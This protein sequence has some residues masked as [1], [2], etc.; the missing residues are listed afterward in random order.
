MSALAV[1]QRATIAGVRLLLATLLLTLSFAAAGAQSP[2][3]LAMRSDTGLPLERLLAGER[4]LA[5]QAINAALQDLGTTTRLRG[6]LL[7]LDGKLALRNNDA[8]HARTALHEA[9]QVLKQYGS[10][11]DLSRLG[12]QQIQLAIQQP[13]DPSEL[14]RRFIAATELAHAA[15]DDWAAANIHLLGAYV[16]AQSG[17]FTRAQQLAEAG[18]EIARPLLD[19]RL[20]AVL[21]NNL[22]NARK[23]LGI[24]GGALDAHFQALALRRKLVDEPGIIQG[25]SNIALVYQRMEDWPQARR[26]SEE[27]LQRSNQQSNVGERTRIALN[28]AA[29][30]VDSGTAADAES[31]LKLLDS[32]RSE[33]ENHRPE[34]RYSL[35]STEA[36][37]LNRMDKREQALAKGLE[38]VATARQSSSG[39]LVEVLHTLAIVQLA[40]E[41]PHLSA[42]AESLQE[43]ILL[44]VQVRAASLESE[45]RLK[46]ATVLEHQGDLAGALREWKLHDAINRRINGLDQVRRIAALEQQVANA[47]RERELQDMRTRDLLQKVQI[48]RQRWLGGMGIVTLMAIAL[49]LFSRIRYAQK[50]AHASEREQIA[51]TQQNLLLEKMANTDGL[52]GLHNRKWMH[53]QLEQRVTQGADSPTLPDDADECILAILDVDHF[54]AINDTHGHDIG[55]TV[56]T[57]IASLMKAGLPEGSACAR[58]G[59]EE[60]LMLLQGERGAMIDSLNAFRSALAARRDWPAEMV[61]SC[62]IGVA[63]R[64]SGENTGDWLKRA[65]LALY[66]A[67]RGGRNR[68]VAATREHREAQEHVGGSYPQTANDQR[69]S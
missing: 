48:S 15:N 67:K 44:A 34:W 32:L 25:L 35:L 10:D 59:G 52:T 62:S 16:A 39:D 30:L 20:T 50:R 18:L 27:A 46:L 31:A 42:A 64:I 23:N 19:D 51:L 53:Q 68:V 12:L 40:Q 17:E 38:A 58:W 54:K 41:P 4:E 13:E 3:V 5:Q 61:V 33:V 2:Q 56:L 28:H 37:A 69:P 49:A 7:L 45:L 9:E 11:R 26:Y 47:D 60:F 66:A 29:L 63:E 6:L 1:A 55:D 43:A 22:A 21:L 36:M 8:S 14:K 65:D 24:L 57:G